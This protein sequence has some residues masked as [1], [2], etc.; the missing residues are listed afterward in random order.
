MTFHDAW[1]KFRDEPTLLREIDEEE[2]EH[3]ADF[4][5]DM[6]EDDLPFEHLFGS[7]MR[8]LI[9]FDKKLMP[10]RLQDFA[11]RMTYRPNQP[12]SWEIDFDTGMMRREI[13]SN[14]GMTEED[15]PIWMPVPL[16]KSFEKANKEH[17]AKLEK[18]GWKF[19]TQQ[20]KIGKFLTKYKRLKEKAEKAKWTPKP[21]TNAIDYDAAEKAEGEVYDFAGSY[22]GSGVGTAHAQEMLDTWGQSGGKSKPLAIVLSRHPIDILRMSDY[23]HIQSCHSPTS[24]GGQGEYYACAVTEAHGHGAIAYLVNLE[25]LGEF[26]EGPL[27]GG[28]FSEWDDEELF[29]D[30]RRGVEGIEPIA[31]VRI[32]KFVYPKKGSLS[33]NTRE[34]A[35]Q[36]AVPEERVYG[37]DIGGFR[38]EIRDWLKTKQEDKMKDLP[39]TGDGTV[40]LLDDFSLVGG[41]YTDT[42]L[43]SLFKRW[44]PDLKF[45]GHPRTYHEPEEEVKS[46]IGMN[47]VSEFEQAIQGL[48]NDYRPTFKVNDFRR[49]LVAA[50]AEDDGAGSAYID[51]NASMQ[52]LYPLDEFK[53][54]PH[55]AYPAMEYLGTHFS[56][57]GINLFEEGRSYI[58]KE[59]ENVVIEMEFDKENL[60]S[61]DNGFTVTGYLTSP[62]EYEELLS[63]MQDQLISAYLAYH[64]EIKTYLRREGIMDGGAILNLAQDV[65]TDEFRTTGWEV[66]TDDEY[67]PG[68]VNAKLE[69]L[70]VPPIPENRYREFKI[71]LREEIIEAALDSGSEYMEYAKVGG[72]SYP[73]TW[74]QDTEDSTGGSSAIKSGEFEL[75]FEV[76][77][78]DPDDVVNTM[79]AVVLTVSPKAVQAMAIRVAEEVLSDSEKDAWGRKRRSLQENIQNNW[80]DFINS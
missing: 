64:A 31:R 68:H 40:I 71:R 1:K 12:G 16:N 60:M 3:I 67:M 39:R 42:P 44:L 65:G 9:P 43:D 55:N 61:A 34:W 41:T 5:T 74:I 48:Q 62:D 6:K 32:R 80:R 36:L 70:K 8:V 19:K 58:R 24:R 17:R 28:K 77:G 73:N 78:D 72:P 30:K 7:S 49:I 4:L 13:W 26:V 22:F 33:R 56:D 35:G 69:G 63:M 11:N 38:D 21:G 20:M 52:F 45:D 66:A 59:G 10:R 37:P 14:P 2:F 25:Q 53:Q 76:T 15:R 75:E 29:A 57:M 47:T 54:L 51:V 50:N 18:E 46:R 27:G 79:L 23:E